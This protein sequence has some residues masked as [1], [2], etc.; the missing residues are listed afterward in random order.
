M[1]QWERKR[2]GVG[3]G[4]YEEGMKMQSEEKKIREKKSKL[5]QERIKRNWK[6]INER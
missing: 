3:K 1:I 5:K 6:E 4:S 2:K